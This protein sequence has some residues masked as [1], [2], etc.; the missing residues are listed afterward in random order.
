MNQIQVLH[1]F[2]LN[3]TLISLFSDAL[4][5]FILNLRGHISRHESMHATE[6]KQIYFILKALIEKLVYTIKLYKW[7]LE[8]NILKLE[9]FMVIAQKL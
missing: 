2:Q 3:H 6:T 1:T 7:S 5:V 9:S 4:M 8:N